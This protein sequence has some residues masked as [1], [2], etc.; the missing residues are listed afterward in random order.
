MIL[1]TQ[2]WCVLGQVGGGWKVK[3]AQLEKS[4]SFPKRHGPS[5]SSMC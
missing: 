3:V 5:D 1:V 4:M 2:F